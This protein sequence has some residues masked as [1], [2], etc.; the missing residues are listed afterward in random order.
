MSD[1]VLDT[2]PIKNEDTVEELICSNH[3][4]CQEKMGLLKAQFQELVRSLKPD[5]IEIQS[6]ASYDSEK[7]IS[8][9][10]FNE[11]GISLLRPA[12]PTISHLASSNVIIV[13]GVK[14][15]DTLIQ[16]SP[17]NITVY[18][19]GSSFGI[20]I[21]YFM[22]AS[23]DFDSFT[24]FMPRD[25]LQPRDENMIDPPPGPADYLEEVKQFIKNR[26]ANQDKDIAAIVNK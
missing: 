1:T 11:A 20:R 13:D 22:A 6:Q 23:N 26:L 2:S 3:P 16:V 8:A 25:A 10:V 19:H 9:K 21:D 18:E 15:N 12:T 14:T 5:R 17:F 7:L 4:D 24:T